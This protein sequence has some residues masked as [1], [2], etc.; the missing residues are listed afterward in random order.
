M[1]EIA[2]KRADVTNYRKW[3]WKEIREG[4]D[5]EGWNRKCPDSNGQYKVLI[6]ACDIP[7]ET[8]E[9][10]DTYKNGYWLDYA[11]FVIGWKENKT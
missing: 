8:F 9:T 6:C 7:P 5:M 11:Q 10:I 1:K 3:T 2:A 4:K